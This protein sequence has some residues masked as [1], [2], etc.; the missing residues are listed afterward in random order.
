MKLL[1]NLAMFGDGDDTFA[2]HDAA[3]EDARDEL[4]FESALL[5]A[6]FLRMYTVFTHVYSVW[7]KCQV[8][9]RLEVL[10]PDIGT[11]FQIFQRRFTEMLAQLEVTRLDPQRGKS[12]SVLEKATR[13]MNFS[14]MELSVLIHDL[15]QQL[16]PIRRVNRSGKRT[17]D[18]F[19]HSNSD[20]SGRRDNKWRI[21]ES[22]Y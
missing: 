21:T 2:Y 1:I 12:H 11:G 3:A 14:A 17:N 19:L 10:L 13:G 7:L 20:Q 18:H 15:K 8:R 5:Y 6:E 4:K 22:C 9:K 16:R